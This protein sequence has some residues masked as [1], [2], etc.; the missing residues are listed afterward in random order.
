MFTGIVKGVGQIRRIEAVGGDLRITVS[1]EGV[2]L[3][4]YGLGSSICVNGA[5][6]TVVEFSAAGFAADISN[7]TSN[8]TTLG[9]LEAGSR[10]NLEPSLRIGQ[11]L[12]GHW[13]TGHVDGVGMIIDSRPDARSSVYG[14]E[15]PAKLGRYIAR[16]GSI[17]VDGVSLTVNAVEGRRCEVN[18]V[19]HTRELTIIGEYEA[20]TAVNI[21]VD[22]VARYL[23]RLLGRGAGAR[24][25]STETL[26]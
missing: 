17:A 22:I 3:G 26:Q 8:A 14:I 18:I 5:C 7:E 25:T 6:L 2:D 11:P 20:G 21:E 24:E 12:D 19:P 10:V 23:E 15:V 13:V 16:K 4:D 9:R 1:T